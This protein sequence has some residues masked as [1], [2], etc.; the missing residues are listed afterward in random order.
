MIILPLCLRCGNNK[1]FASSHLPNKTP[2]V[3]GSISSLMGNFDGEDIRYFE[4]LGILSTTSKKAFEH[5]ERYFD[6]CL[7]CGSKDIIWP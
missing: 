4:N 7:V 1:S 5:H 2:W 6:I 3:N